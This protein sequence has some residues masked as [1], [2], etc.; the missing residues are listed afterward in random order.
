M[1]STPNN[2]QGVL[3]GIPGLEHHTLYLNCRLLINSFKKCNHPLKQRLEVL[4]ISIEN[5]AQEKNYTVIIYSTSSRMDG[6]SFNKSDGVHAFSG[7]FLLKFLLFILLGDHTHETDVTYLWFFSPSHSYVFHPAV[8][9][10]LLFHLSWRNIH[11]MKRIF[12]N[13]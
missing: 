2:S 10:L 9:A 6:S 7:D 3:S 11:L 1:Q 12:P 5:I 13:T 4:Q 8:H